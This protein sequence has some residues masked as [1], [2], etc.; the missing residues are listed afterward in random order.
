MSWKVLY[1]FLI[2]SSLVSWSQADAQQW[3]SDCYIVTVLSS[4]DSM[5]QKVYMRSTTAR[6]QMPLLVSLHSWSGDYRQRDSMALWSAEKNWNYIHPD[7]R[8]P[9]RTISA[10]CSALALQ[11][12]DDAITHAITHANVDTQNIFVIGSSGGGYATLATFMKSRHNIRLFSA[13]VPIADLEAW[14]RESMA[15]KNKYAKEILACTHQDTSKL[16]PIS[17]RDR[18]P[19]FWEVPTQRLAKT[20]LEIFTGIFDGIQGSVPITQAINFY[21]KVAGDCFGSQA[22]LVTDKE[23]LFLLEKRQALG[24]FGQIGSRK[25][26][27]EKQSGNLRLVVFEGNHEMLASY[28]FSQC[29]S[30]AQDRR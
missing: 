11:D 6:I 18:S 15:R 27:L 20:R 24:S 2:G 8:G 14:F 22:D 7:F 9:N 28:A 23:K 16:D 10:C 4:L 17:F 12:I 13:W 1:I 19:L 21:N 5:P 30:Q 25:V 29:V 3:P 26:F